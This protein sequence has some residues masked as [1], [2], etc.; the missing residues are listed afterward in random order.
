MYFKQWRFVTS[1]QT[2]RRGVTIAR[3][4]TSSMTSVR[5]S[6]FVSVHISTVSKEKLKTL[7]VGNGGTRDLFTFQLPS[8]K[9]QKPT[10]AFNLFDFIYYMRGISVSAGL[11]LVTLHQN[12]FLFTHMP[13]VLVPKTIDMRTRRSLGWPIGKSERRSF[14]VNLSNY[15]V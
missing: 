1:V 4:I 9:A 7:N 6:N 13:S 3:E 15:Y 2:T 10:V 8:G 14:Q 5:P 12:L 11:F